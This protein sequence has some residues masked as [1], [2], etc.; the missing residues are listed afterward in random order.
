MVSR[1]Y[2]DW[3]PQRA[4]QPH[5]WMSLIMSPP[6]TLRNYS[7]RLMLRPRNGLAAWANAF[8]SQPPT[9]TTT[10]M[11]TTMPTRLRDESLWP[12]PL[13][14]WIPDSMSRQHRERT[15]KGQFSPF[16]LSTGRSTY[17]T[18]DDGMLFY[19][20]TSSNWS[21][22][23]R[24]LSIT[25]EHLFGRPLPAKDLLFDGCVYELDWDGSR[26]SAGP[27]APVL[28]ALDH[29]IYLINA[30]KFHC[31]QIF[32]LFDDGEIMPTLYEF[33]N[34]P[35]PGSVTEELWYVHL[36]LI[37][38]FGK[39][40]TC[41][42]SQSKKAPG[43]DMFIKAVALLPSEIMLWRRPLQSCEVLC[44]IALYLQCLDCRI[45]AHNYVCPAR[46]PYTSIP[47]LPWS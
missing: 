46:I 18:A 16:V 30:V 37:L 12:V 35:S 10:A 41:K 24:I 2:V 17:M 45:A 32:H 13:Q 11:S 4:G 44:C 28:P 19:L 3:R 39:A 6:G 1:G 5:Y 42:Q 21:F 8:Q 15:R 34:D 7:V 14:H 22:A 40:F 38:A 36:L 23:R 25:H 31:G 27:Q 33:Y 26:T 20:G 47:Q 43:D 29:A 9:T